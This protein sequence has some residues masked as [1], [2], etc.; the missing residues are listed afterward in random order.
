LGT[1]ED[2]R[3]VLIDRIRRDE[4]HLSCETS[5]TRQLRLLD[6]RLRPQRRL[7]GERVPLVDVALHEAFALLRHRATNV[8]RNRTVAAQNLG[9]S[10]IDVEA[11]DSERCDRER[12]GLPATRRTSDYNHPRPGHAASPRLKRR[13]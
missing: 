13:V 2:A 12:A 1:L 9:A 11:I 8:A 4:D 5:N 3:D 6:R 10:V 7:D